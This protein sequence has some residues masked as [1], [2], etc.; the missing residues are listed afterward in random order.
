M[1]GLTAVTKEEW[2]NQQVADYRRYLADDQ[3]TGYG[4]NCWLFA[5]KAASQSPHQVPK[6]TLDEFRAMMI[7]RAEGMRFEGR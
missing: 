3:A 4:G 2:I 7:G 5:T 1:E 6:P